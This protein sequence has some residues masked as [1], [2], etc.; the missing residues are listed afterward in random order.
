MFERRLV[1][2]ALASCVALS[3]L[4][5]DEARD[6]KKVRSDCELAHMWKDP[7]APTA[8]N[9]CMRHGHYALR[10]SPLCQVGARRQLCYDLKD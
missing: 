4:A 1:L 3:A 7:P 5:S 8:F 9:R 6:F 2:L 10:L